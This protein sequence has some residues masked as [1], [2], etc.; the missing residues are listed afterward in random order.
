MSFTLGTVYI[1]VDTT[2]TAA[3]RVRTYS[4]RT[5][6]LSGALSGVPADSPLPDTLIRTLCPRSIH[7]HQAAWK[8]ALAS[9][10][11][12]ATLP[13]PA[14]CRYEAMAE[15]LRHLAFDFPNSVGMKPDAQV[16]MLGDI[17]TGLAKILAAPLVDQASAD[18]LLRPALAHFIFGNEDLTLPEDLMELENWIAGGKTMTDRL[19]SGIWETVPCRRAPEI[20]DLDETL[21]AQKLSD[22]LTERPLCFTGAL[23]RHRNHPLVS[24]VIEQYGIGARCAVVARIVDVAELWKKR[25]S[26]EIIKADSVGDNTGISRVSTAAGVL[27]YRLSVHSGLVNSLSVVEP[28]EWNFA[29]GSAAST[30]LSQLSISNHEQFEKEARWIVEALDPGLACVVRFK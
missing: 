1:D 23:T 25:R 26:L 13:D 6:E 2:G 3:Q 27:M 11:F 12:P 14:A 9:A 20:I 7:A 29:Q 10:G 16:R 17:R 30:M 18:A 15:H 22:I 19:L 24:Q 21:P 4:T 28:V 5:G 8:Y